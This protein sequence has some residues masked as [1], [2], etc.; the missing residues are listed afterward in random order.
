[1]GLVIIH[2]ELENCKAAL[3]F[4]EKSIQVVLDFWLVLVTVYRVMMDYPRVTY[5]Q[6]LKF[7]WLSLSPLLYD[8]MSDAQQPIYIYSCLQCLWSCHYVFTM[9][10]QKRLVIIILPVKKGTHL[11]KAQMQDFYFQIFTYLSSHLKI[12]FK[13]LKSEKQLANIS[14]RIKHVSCTFR[15]TIH[16]LLPL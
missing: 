10:L 16:F 6:F 15:W 2:N 11:L 7:Q 8:C 9:F 5:N 4:A 1:M 13:H 14:I 12:L 3:Q